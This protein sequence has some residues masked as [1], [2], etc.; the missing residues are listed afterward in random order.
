MKYKVGDRFNFTSSNVKAEILKKIDKNKFLLKWEDG[1]EIIVTNENL[2]NDIKKDTISFISSTPKKKKNKLE[3]RV[4][5]LKKFYILLNERHIKE[6]TSL[7]E[8]L[9]ETKEE[10]E[11]T[12]IL[13]EAFKD[14]NKKTVKISDFP[15]EQVPNDVKIDLTPETPNKKVINP[16]KTLE[17]RLEELG[18]GV[19]EEYSYGVVLFMLINLPNGY[20]VS[21]PYYDDDN[22][23][24]EKV[25][26]IIE[27]LK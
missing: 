18:C 6:I 11:N 25:K 14:A 3:K 19:S 23:I 24:I 1:E 2:D 17:E 8:R 5:E 22:E 13:F 26:Q 16:D 12:Q 7:N 4:K 9:E 10:L 15:S 21:F 20:K 27:I